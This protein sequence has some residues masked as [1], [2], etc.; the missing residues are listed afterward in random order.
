[1]KKE[2]RLLA[3]M[4]IGFWG[5]SSCTNELM[6]EYSFTDASNT[7]NHEASDYRPTTWPEQ[8]EYALKFHGA[9]AIK[10]RNA[11]SAS[12]YL[13]SY[14]YKGSILS[15]QDLVEVKDKLCGDNAYIVLYSDLANKQYEIVTIGEIRQRC[16]EAGIPMKLD[17]VSKVLDDSLQIGMEVIECTWNYNGNS[18]TS[19]A[20]AHKDGSILYETIGYY[21]LEDNPTASTEIETYIPRIKKRTESDPYAPVFY[22]SGSGTTF[23]GLSVMS[24]EFFCES[25]FYRDGVLRA[26][27]MYAQYHTL[28]GWSGTADI[29]TTGG[30]IDSTKFHTFAWGY[31]YSALATVEL[32]F[33]KGGFT[34][35]GGADGETGTET[36]RIVND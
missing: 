9:K 36:H 21:L 13:E 29:Q 1:M 34:I 27:D 10:T 24:Y 11:K 33:S 26:V 15:E 28:I 4:A 22:Y 2:I 16:A 12:I 30:I 6:P 14:E 17:S 5:L 20:V 7:P 32:T 19:T 3:F 25:S 8:M 31:A 35:S 23:W 18:Y